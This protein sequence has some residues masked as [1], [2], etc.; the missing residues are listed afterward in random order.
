MHNAC[1]YYDM[2]FSLMPVASMEKIIPCRHKGHF[3]FRVLGQVANVAFGRWIHFNSTLC[4]FLIACLSI[5]PVTGISLTLH[6]H[7]LKIY[8]F[9]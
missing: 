8:Y 3:A 2:F 5:Q 6:Y 7:D 9:F 4:L 1:L